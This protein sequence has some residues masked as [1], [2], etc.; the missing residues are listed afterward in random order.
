[1]HALYPHPDPESP[2]ASPPHSPQPAASTQTPLTPPHISDAFQ[3]SPLPDMIPQ[4]P[5]GQ[6]PGVQPEDSSAFSLPPHCPSPGPRPTPP[7]RTPSILTATTRDI[8]STTQEISDTISVPLRPPSHANSAAAPPAEPP[9]RTPGRPLA[10]IPPS[11][12]S[13]SDASVHSSNHYTPTDPPPGPPRSQSPGPRYEAPRPRSLLVPAEQL[14]R[15][16]SP[17]LDTFAH[18]QAPHSSEDTGMPPRPHSPAP[19]IAR[20]SPSP[21]PAYPSHTRTSTPGARPWPQQLQPSPFGD[22]EAPM[23]TPE[24]AYAAFDQS[25]FSSQD[26]QHAHG[27]PGGHGRMPSRHMHLPDSTDSHRSTRMS[28]G[29]HG[30]HNGG[31]PARYRSGGPQHLPPYAIHAGYADPRMT[32]PPPEPLQTAA[33]AAAAG[34]G[35]GR[36]SP[37]PNNTMLRT[38]ASSAGDGVAGQ[39]PDSRSAVASGRKAEP[40]AAKSFYQ[41]VGFATIGG[42]DFAAA[43]AAAIAASDAVRANAVAQARHI[44]RMGAVTAGGRPASLYTKNLLAH[45]NITPDAYTTLPAHFDMP[46]P[47]AA[48]AA[49]SLRPA[50]AAAVTYRQRG[51]TTLPVGAGVYSSLDAGSTDRAMLWRNAGAAPL[52]VGAVAIGAPG[53]SAQAPH[54]TSLC[55][56]PPQHDQVRT[57]QKLYVSIPPH[58]CVSHS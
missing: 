10:A 41:P 28:S 45:A 6:V 49:A 52:S 2:T 1:M 15:T 34:G 37:L 18:F 50:T 47:P 3:P 25:V 56:P 40:R 42:S 21:Q 29:A 13:N 39:H 38:H 30:R 44:G 31:G 20:R 16:A 33:E 23:V 14:E 51:F 9:R 4:P 8:N 46:P 7:K 12:S 57:S 19:A 53:V 5:L 32:P 58:C 48:A 11:S 36:S 35:A 43:E 27:R 26:G 55:R 24:Q 22:F 54:P 17:P